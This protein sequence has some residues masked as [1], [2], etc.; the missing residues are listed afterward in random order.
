LNIEE[1]V[2]DKIKALP[3]LNEKVQA[4]ALNSYLIQKRRLDE[5]LQKEMEQ[6]EFK[7]RLLYAPYVDEINQIINGDYELN[8]GDIQ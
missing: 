7:Y 4:I 3:T 1:E 2:E 5:Q 8:D 6:I